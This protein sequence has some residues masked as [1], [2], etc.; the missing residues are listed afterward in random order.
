MNG[1]RER[2]KR[3]L[4]WLKWRRKFKWYAKSAYFE[5]PE[6]VVNPQ[7]ISLDWGAHVRAHARLEC[8]QFQDALGQ[9]LFAEGVTAQFYLHVASAVRVVFEERVLI[10]GRVFISDHD[11]GMPWTSGSLV[12]EPVLIGAGSWLG[13]GCAVL[14]G[15]QLG[16]GC[17][18][19]ANA[20]VTKDFPAGSILGGVPARLIGRV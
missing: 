5:A 15:V 12:A 2:I 4:A 11:H 13:E 8:I 7:G 6:L 14:K 1:M 17:V 20:V 10:A 9:I 3:R 18:V 19:G 16:A